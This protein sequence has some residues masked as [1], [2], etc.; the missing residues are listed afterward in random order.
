VTS[1]Y[2]PLYGH[3]IFFNDVTL[4]AYLKIVRGKTRFTNKI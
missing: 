4:S 2:F 1:A 3:S